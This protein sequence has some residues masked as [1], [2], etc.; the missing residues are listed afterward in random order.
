MDSDPFQRLRHIHQLALTFL[1]YP[2]ATHRRFEH[3]VGVMGLAEQVYDVVTSPENIHEAVSDLFEPLL[4]EDQRRYWRRV[5]RLAALCHDIGHLPFSHAAEGLLPA[6][7]DHER[8]TVDLILK[9]G[10]GDLLLLTKPAV[11]PLDVAK[12]AVGP[13][14]FKDVP[15]SDWETILSEIITGDAF[16][17]DRI[18]YLLRDSYHAGVAYGRFDHHRLIDS[19]RILPRSYGNSREP[20]LGVDFGGLQSAEALLLARY[21]MYT[22]VYFHPVR[23]AYDIHLR[24]FLKEWLPDGMFPVDLDEHLSL[25]DNEVLSS[26]RSA[27]AT[28][29]APG[30][31]H[32]QRVLGRKHFKVLYERNP[33]DLKQNPKPGEAIYRAAVEKLGHQDV[34]RDTYTQKSNWVDFPVLTRDNRVLSSLELS[35]VLRQLPMVAVDYVM[36]KPERLP[37]AKAWLKA[38]KDQILSKYVEGE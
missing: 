27:A 9:T 13:K 21:F 20:A 26:M 33:L 29:G 4:S 14:K 28:P 30:N 8:L 5:V 25:T 31:V 37:E 19:L 1:V 2:G 23:R 6:G 10:I 22:Q 11:S 18:D 7:W 12:I 15:F 24:D 3:S 34:R 38:E 17:V 36:V 32:A 16:G 35:G